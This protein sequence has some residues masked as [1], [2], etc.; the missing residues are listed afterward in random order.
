MTLWGGAL[1]RLQT[2]R[3]PTYAAWFACG[4]LVVL[5]TVFLAS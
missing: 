2:G 3:I 1:R 5:A 4:V